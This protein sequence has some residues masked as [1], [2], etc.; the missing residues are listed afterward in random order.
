MREV[1]PGV[2]GKNP[3]PKTGVLC[4]RE[5]GFEPPRPFGHWHLKPARLPFRHSRATSSTQSWPG[6]RTANLV[7]AARSS[8]TD[9]SGKTPIGPRR[10]SRGRSQTCHPAGRGAPRTPHSGPLRHPQRLPPGGMK[11]HPDRRSAT[12]SAHV[13]TPGR[14]N[15]PARSGDA[16]QGHSQ[17][18]PVVSDVGVPATSG[19]PQMWETEFPERMLPCS[20]HERRRTMGLLTDKVERGIEKAVRGVFSTGSRAQVEPVDRE[21][22]PPRSGQQGHHHRRRPDPGPQRLRCT[23]Q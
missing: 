17:T 2:K 9:N 20:R 13:V 16:R 15:F 5:G 18:R 3:G 4:V 19:L 22:P 14:R 6:I 1:R 7:K 11:M 8:I 23:P 12:L 21:P 10:P